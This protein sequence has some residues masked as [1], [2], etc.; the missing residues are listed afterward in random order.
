MTV[1]SICQFFI[2]QNKNNL[3]DS[4]TINIFLRLIKNY[5][6]KATIV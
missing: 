4:V 3:F 2:Y 6:Q 1:E 5:A